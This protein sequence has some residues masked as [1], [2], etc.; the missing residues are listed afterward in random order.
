MQWSPQGLARVTDWKTRIGDLPLVA[1]G[2]I[3]P[4]RAPGVVAAG[5]DSIAVI[6]DFFTN[7]DPEARVRQ[8]LVWAA[9]LR[10]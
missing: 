6:T 8:W 9:A 2:G 1:I 3:T 7:P 4:E 5:A 10:P